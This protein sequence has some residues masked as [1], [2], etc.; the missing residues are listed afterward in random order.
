MP[1]LQNFSVTTRARARITVPRATISAQV[2]DSDTG[3]V[4]QDFTGANALL[5]PEVI[6]TL[7]TEESDAFLTYIAFWLIQKKAGMI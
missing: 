2:T 3:A 7:T 1:D 5:F 4:L 6:D